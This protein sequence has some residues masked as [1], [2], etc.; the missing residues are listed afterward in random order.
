MSA[1]R[2]SIV[3]CSSSDVTRSVIGSFVYQ[4]WRG[5]PA[6]KFSA[7][8]AVCNRP[9]RDGGGAV[10]GARVP[11]SC[12]R[13]GQASRPPGRRNEQGYNMDLAAGRI[14][15]VGEATDDDAEVLY[16]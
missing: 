6:R 13:A 15:D 16:I 7:R 2:S 14:A 1:H 3:A 4:Q 11:P 5:G 10:T 9:A 8:V 12:G